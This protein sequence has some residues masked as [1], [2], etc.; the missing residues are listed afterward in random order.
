MRIL[1]TGAT[2]CIGRRLVPFLRGRGHDVIGG[3]RRPLGPGDRRVDLDDVTTL[4]PALAGC[5][6]A[7][8]LVH[9]LARGDAYAAWEQRVATS[10]S[11][12]CR[13]VGVP[14]IVYLGGVQPLAGASPHLRAR[15]ETGAALRSAGVDVVELRAGMIVA[16][17]SASF[18][19]A[20]DIAARLPIIVRPPWLRSR[21]RPVAVVDVIAA[22]ERGL[23]ADAGVHG[24]PGPE[25]LGGDETLAILGRL[26]GRTLRF[27]DVP[28]ADHHLVAAALSRVSDANAD[29]VAELVPGMTG[30]LLGDD[31]DGVF[32]LMP[33]HLRQ[34]FERAA[35]LALR[36]GSSAS[37]SA[38]AWE[39]LLRAA[40]G[41]R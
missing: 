11:R 33:G 30:D 38:W 34:P 14:R 2:G 6:A 7:V 21:Q 10:F 41:A 15:A 36:E 18:V 9:G 20:R 1:V 3:V 35:Q 25:V 40:G 32:A 16:S 27:V 24:C 17:D 19:L 8:Y 23:T 31:G 22:L 37:L 26:Q 29:V 5:A 12:V 4:A 28:W 13:E 39:R